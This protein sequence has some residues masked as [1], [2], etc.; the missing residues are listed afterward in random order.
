MENIDKFN[1]YTAKIFSTLYANFPIPIAI[2]TRMIVHGQPFPEKMNTP[3]WQH[4]RKTDQ[5]INFCCASLAWLHKNG[6]FHCDGARQYLR[7]SGV[8][9]TPKCLEAMAAIPDSLNQSTGN[10]IT[11]F[12]K[13][14]TFDSLKE[15]GKR[16]LSGLIGTAIR[17]GYSVIQ[18]SMI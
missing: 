3:D 17:S 6:Y 16:E 8:V 7:I 10:K 9:M 4:I 14:V 12:I 5:E 2:D 18:Q 13:D 11:E 15:T 1:F